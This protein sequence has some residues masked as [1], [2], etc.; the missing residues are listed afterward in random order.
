MT[1][2]ILTLNNLQKP[3]TEGLVAIY[4]KISSLFDAF[5]SS[6][7]MKAWEEAAR[8]RAQYYE[9]QYTIKELS[10]L[11]DKELAD[12]GISRSEIR[13]VAYSSNYRS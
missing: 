11:T 13:D 7:F 8:K 9:A 1:H 12:I 4:M 6:N 10:R 5:M 2:L 3:V